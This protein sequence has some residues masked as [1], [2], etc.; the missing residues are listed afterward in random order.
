MR[1]ITFFG[2]HR[3]HL[4]GKALEH[5]HRYGNKLPYKIETLFL[6]ECIKCNDVYSKRIDGDWVTDKDDDDDDRDPPKG[7]AMSPDD[8]F[9]AL[10]KE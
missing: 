8:Y 9:Q 10:T 6:Y 3:Y 2:K 5:T 1:C 7:P 4:K